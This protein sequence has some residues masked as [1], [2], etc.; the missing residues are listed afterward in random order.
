MARVQTLSEAERSPGIP[1][2]LAAQELTARLPHIVLEARRVAASVSHGI[3]GR[4]RAGPGESFWQFRPFMSGESATRVDWRRS[5]RDGRLYVRE[6]EWEA[7]HSIYLWADRSASMGFVSSLAAQSKVERALVL[8]L[9][10]SET[11]VDA[12]ERVGLM[13]LVPPRASRNIVERF[14]ELI[15]KDAAGHDADLPAAEALPPLSEAVLVS[16]FLV[17]PP[18]F[19]AVVG[20]LAARGARGHAIMIIDPVEETFPFTGQ[21]ELED[22]EAGL[23]LRIGDAVLWGED[24]RRRIAIHRD[25]I[26]AALKRRGWTLTLHHTDRPASE[27]A[28]RVLTQLSAARGGRS[29][30]I[31]ARGG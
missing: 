5:A 14:V 2:A 23:R 4:R 10:L 13:G 24:Y 19:D 25:A 7:A 26:G 31:G 27:A 17:E 22:P 3:H 15:A 29:G 8:T 6:R 28:L 20:Q 21:A 12:G 18:A 30:L 9:A 11:L 1:H 16:D